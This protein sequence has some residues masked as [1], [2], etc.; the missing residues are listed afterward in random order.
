[1]NHPTTDL[2]LRVN[3]IQAAFGLEY[4]LETPRAEEL[5]AADPYRQ[6]NTSFSL[7]QWRGG[8]MV[9]HTVIDA[10]MGIAPSLLELEH[11]HGV[12]VVHEL[13][14]SHGHF[15]HVAGIDWLATS[16]AYNGRADQPRPLA[17]HASPGCWRTGPQLF[18]P[19]LLERGRARHLP[20]EPGREVV[21]GDV[22]VT[23]FAVD[24]KASA[25]GALGFVV[26]HGGR[27]IVLTCDFLRIPAED[28]PLFQGADVC[29]MEATNWHPKPEIGHTSVLDN[30]ALL[31]KWRPRRTYFVHYSGL[32]DRKHTGDPINGPMALTRLQKEI[33][34]L[35][36]DLDVQVA[37][38]G[39]IL[40]KDTPWPA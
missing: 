29:F 13:L 16:I 28:D 6:A 39:M 10:G 17:V 12:P 14:L 27:K 7:V 5:C 4:G 34:R 38:H 15:D 8:E 30:L 35:R 19:Y 2:W 3:G 23:P 20:L 18:F 26:R 25:P 40:G 31:R 32:F 37:R 11:R 21:L 24:H 9:R 36:G 33:D 22:R 1:M